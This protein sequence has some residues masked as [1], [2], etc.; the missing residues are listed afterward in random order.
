MESPLR[1]P[2]SNLLWVY[3][4]VVFFFAIEGILLLQNRFDTATFLVA[5]L[6]PGVANTL[7]NIRQFCE[8]AIARVREL[9]AMG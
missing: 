8:G 6:A 2:R 9:S 5:L 1:S 3:F 4:F 7:R